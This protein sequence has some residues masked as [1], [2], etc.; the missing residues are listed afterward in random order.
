VRGH[1]VIATR[2]FADE[3]LDGFLVLLAQGTRRQHAIGLQRG[4]SVRADGSEGI[5]HI[6]C[7]FHN[8]GVDLGRGAGGGLK[9]R[10]G[11]T[12]YG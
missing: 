12:G 11:N 6:A 3:Q 1:A 8:L 10:G 4:R 7:R 2:D 5:R 9:G